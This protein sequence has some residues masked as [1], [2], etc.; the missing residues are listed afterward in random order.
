MQEMQETQVWS[1]GQEDPLEEDMATH[2]SI[3]A[4]EVPWTEEP[5]GLQSMGL[6][7]RT[8]LNNWACTWELLNGQGEATS[9]I[10]F[11]S[12]AHPFGWGLFSDRLAV[13]LCSYQRPDHCSYQRPTCSSAELVKVRNYNEEPTDRFLWSE[14]RG[15]QKGKN[16]WGNCRCHLLLLL[17]LS[18][19]SRVQPSATPW[20]AAHQAPPSM[21]FSR[22]E[23]WSG[24]PLPWIFA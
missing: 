15:K 7:S 1:L 12:V 20:T 13:S 8:Q 16:G 3:F 23:C 22:Q 9:P 19:F 24:V 2:S 5:G 14:L 18:H 17:L 6:Q 10:L 11:P 4:W 21:G